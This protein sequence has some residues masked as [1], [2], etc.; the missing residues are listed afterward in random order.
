M[1]IPTGKIKENNPCIIQ[2][3]VYRSTGFN[4]PK[5]LVEIFKGCL[6]TFFGIISPIY[7]PKVINFAVYQQGVD[8]G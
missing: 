5:K 6:N 7:I 2:M 8:E 3:I 4:K 1:S